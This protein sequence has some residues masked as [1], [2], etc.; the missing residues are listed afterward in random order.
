MS[1]Y[2]PERRL[3]SRIYSN[4][5]TQKKR[6][7]N[8]RQFPKE[9][10]VAKKYL[11]GDPEYLTTGEMKNPN[12]SEIPVRR[13]KSIKATNSTQQREDVGK[14][15]PSVTVNGIANQCSHYKNPCAEF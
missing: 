6:T 10:K 8:K 5:Q 2:A 13:A 3:I 14:G 11:R 1:S 15:K 12:S 4:S 9:Q 7:L